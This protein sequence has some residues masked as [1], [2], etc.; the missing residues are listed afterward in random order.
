MQNLVNIIH[1]KARKIEETQPEKITGGITHQKFI[2]YFGCQ[3]FS[4]KCNNWTVIEIPSPDQIDQDVADIIAE[5]LDDNSFICG[6][7][8]S[9]IYRN[10]RFN[11]IDI[12]FVASDLSN[13]PNLDK[14]RTDN[15]YETSSCLTICKNDIKIQFIKR[16]YDNLG[17]IL[18][19]FDLDSCRIAINNTGTFLATW[20]GIGAQCT[21]INYINPNCQSSSFNYRIKKYA[22]KGFT[23][24]HI[25]DTNNKIFRY[26]NIK[27]DY[28]S[29]FAVVNHSHLVEFMIL[30]AR[31]L[32]FCHG[33]FYTKEFL[34]A[35]DYDHLHLIFNRRVN[36][37]CAKIIS[38]IENDPKLNP[39]E[40]QQESEKY[41][42]IWIEN[43]DFHIK[44]IIE[45][46]YDYYLSIKQYR[47]TNP[48]SQLTA[49]FNPTN[50]KLRDL[51]TAIG[52]DLLNK[53]MRLFLLMAKFA[54]FTIIQKS[55][56]SDKI[57]TIHI[58]IP[59]YIIYMVAKFY[60]DSKIK[61]DCDYLWEDD[62]F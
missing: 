33:P 24:E 35:Q 11:D 37:E 44:K 28:G 25:G 2:N 52:Y 20:N 21:L 51:Y 46:E 5:F 3:E 23:P 7:S 12:F 8:A 30:G 45:E 13:L 50:Y 9:D 16:I 31:N 54:K 34:L 62:Q 61:E 56:N 1:K 38:D 43:K 6:G 42:C 59:K 40:K 41:K 14:Y 29:V 19:G 48:G 47:I 15:Y 60:Y 55:P 39:F 49:S 4:R 10:K 36:K 17:Q 18:G 53:S 22:V 26:L 58:K 57:Y 27:H 32:Y